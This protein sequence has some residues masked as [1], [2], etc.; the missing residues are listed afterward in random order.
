MPILSSRST[1]FATVA[2]PHPFQ[3]PG[4]SHTCP[5]SS[6]CDSWLSGRLPAPPAL[7]P[8]GLQLTLLCAG[9]HTWLPLGPLCLLIRSYTP[10]SEQL[11]IFYPQHL[12]RNLIFF[13]NAVTRTNV[14]IMSCLLPPDGWLTPQDRRF[15]FCV[16]ATDYLSGLLLFVYIL[17]RLPVKERTVTCWSNSLAGVCVAALVL[18]SSVTE[19]NMGHLPHLSPGLRLKLNEWMYVK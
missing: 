17:L 3:V 12:E 19:Q 1:T 5:L 6:S 18:A 2:C 15:L 16:C 10:H 13:L 8:V 11:S 7:L 9:E 4:I 14:C